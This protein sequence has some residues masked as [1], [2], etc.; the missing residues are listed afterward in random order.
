MCYFGKTN[1]AFPH[2]RQAYARH[3]LRLWGISLGRQKREARIHFRKRFGCLVLARKA[4]LDADYLSQV[5]GGV[6]RALRFVQPIEPRQSVGVR[7]PVRVHSLE[8]IL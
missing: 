4:S 7:M 2:H 8:Q 3:M 6:F 1:P 5:H